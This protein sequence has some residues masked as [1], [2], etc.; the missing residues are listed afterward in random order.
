MTII[1]PR[2]DRDLHRHPLLVL[3]LLVLSVAAA[4]GNWG[5][6]SI[7]GVTG[8]LFVAGRVAREG[9]QLLALNRI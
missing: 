1:V 4:Q 5:S 2:C 3:A 9:R 6:V 7:A 8:L